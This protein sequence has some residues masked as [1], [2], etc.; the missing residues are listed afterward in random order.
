M[1]ETD[2]LRAYLKDVAGLAGLEVANVVLPRDE[3]LEANGLRLHYLDWGQASA[4]P[5]ILLHGGALTAHTWD[6]V[7][8]GLQPEFRCIAPDLRG[9]GDS[10]WALDGDY[11]PDSYRG[12]L[13]ALLAHLHIEHCILVGNSLGGATAARYTAERSPD[14][15]PDALV[16]VDFGPEM[17]EAGRQRLR[18]FTG[19]PRE[20]DS[21]EEF[22]ERAIGFNPQRQRET[23]RRS[24]LNNL[25][26]LPSGKWTWK[27]DPN[28]FGRSAMATA[29]DRWA[30]L[31]R[32]SC[33]TLVVR[34]GRSDMFL[35]EDA[36][37]LAAGLQNGRWIRI[38][39][40][41]HTIQSDRPVELV[42]AIREFLVELALYPADH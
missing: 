11:S 28:R 31:R 13:E 19:G 18:A 6:V 29:A 4:R 27:Y 22:V 24:L 5:V 20:L 3:H 34:G 37:K 25:R 26:Q 16:L 39:G 23:L 36:E 33:P 30:D 14:Q 10:D 8:L 15:Q 12:D 9:H 2:E 42:N 32:V 38:D 40:A 7:A 21:V 41:S 17:R 35:D 1:L